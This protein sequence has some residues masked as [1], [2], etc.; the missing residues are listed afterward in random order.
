MTDYFIKKEGINKENIRGYN[1]EELTHTNVAAIIAAGSADVGMGIY[2]VA[3]IY[4][5]DF[6]PICEEHYDFLVDERAM[7]S[8]LFLEFLK[9]IQGE[10]FRKRLEKIGGYIVENIGDIID[11]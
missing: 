1:R 8:K 2:S 6:I 4:G 7:N 10:E 3:N 5:L 9:V 11:F